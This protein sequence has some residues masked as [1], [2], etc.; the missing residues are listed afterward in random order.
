LSDES[1][2]QRG[3]EPAAGD[4]Q[5][6]LTFGHTEALLARLHR[7]GDGERTKFQ[8][9]LRNFQR[10]KE[11]PIPEGVGAGRGKTVL[12]RPSHVVEIAVALELTQLGLLPERIEEIFRFNEWAL[13]HGVAN[14]AWGLQR[15]GGFAEKAGERDPLHS[16]LYF[17]P[18]ALDPLMTNDVREEA[19]ASATLSYG[20]DREV[21]RDFGAWMAGPFIRRLS[22]INLT[23]MI[24]GL[25]SGRSD[26]GR[27]LFLADIEAW[28]E[29]RLRRYIRQGQ[30]H[31]RRLEASGEEAER[32]GQRRTG[33]PNLSEEEFE[34]WLEDDLVWRGDPRYRARLTVERLR[35]ARL[36]SVHEIG[37]V[38]DALAG[39]DNARPQ[40][41]GKT[42][43]KGDAGDGDS[44]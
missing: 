18:V 15:H 38:V 2:V 41:A 40:K 11:Y 32:Q 4:D 24:W 6:F 22:F 23:A 33:L 43:D 34:Q 16:F 9:R 7:I 25:I 21:Q 36:Q 19:G 5:M 14:A 17:D 44:Q 28:Y 13:I 20:S 8:A 10:L 31:K 3:A 39:L 42:Q 27:E 30:E 35:S 12:Y 1:K 29:A 37:G 26:A